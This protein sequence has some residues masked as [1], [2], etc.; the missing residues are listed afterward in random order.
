M[1]EEIKAECLRSLRE[2]EA[3]YIKSIVFWEKAPTADFLGQDW[4]RVHIEGLKKNLEHIR[5]AIRIAAA[6]GA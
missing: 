5:K 6:E 4:N 3:A 1:N 2:E